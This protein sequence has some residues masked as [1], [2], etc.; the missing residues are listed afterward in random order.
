MADPGDAAEMFSEM[1]TVG[2]T[3]A[4]LITVVWI[5]MCVVSDLIVKRNPDKVSQKANV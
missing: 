5:V 3:M 1:A 2:V 4:A